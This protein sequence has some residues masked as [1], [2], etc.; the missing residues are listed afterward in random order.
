M[1]MFIK[2][3]A[4]RMKK[5]VCGTFFKQAETS[6]SQGLNLVVNLRHHEMCWKGPA[7]QAELQVSDDSTHQSFLTQEI[8]KLMSA[9]DTAEPHA[10]SAGPCGLWQKP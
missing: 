2:Y 8:E 7:G 9:G 5:R 4:F 10:H 6:C 1:L 3:M